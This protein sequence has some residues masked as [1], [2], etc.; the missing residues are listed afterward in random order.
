MEN[1]NTISIKKFKEY[2]APIYNKKIDF[3]D[4]QLIQVSIIT[5]KSV[6]ELEEMDIDDF[7]AL[8]ENALEAF[9][10][11]ISESFVTEITI[12][13]VTYFVS[14]KEDG[15]PKITTSDIKLIKQTI[16]D[17]KEMNE[18]DF[19]NNFDIFAAIL[20]KEEKSLN[21]I[22]NI[23]K[24]AK[25]FNEKMPIALIYPYSLKISDKLK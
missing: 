17:K 4:G 6:T 9:N 7:K 18:L 12:D 2:I 22:E 25:I 16:F 10:A 15:S 14:K 5:S 8:K 21:S 3:I 23:Q 11:N 13:N 19:I 20:F 24:R 1:I